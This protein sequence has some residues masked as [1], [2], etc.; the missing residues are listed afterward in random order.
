M[1]GAKGLRDLVPVVM[2]RID[3][4]RSTAF[5][6]LIRLLVGMFEELW[7][8]KTPSGKI[9]PL[10]RP[11]NLPPTKSIY[12]NYCRCHFQLSKPSK[13]VIHITPINS[14][15]NSVSSLYSDPKDA[16]PT[17]IKGAEASKINCFSKNWV[18]DETNW[19]LLLTSVNWI[20]PICVVFVR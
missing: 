20:I 1:L 9:S 2:L 11:E 16:H 5:G 7:K 14:T 3:R 15:A 18:H 10:G 12:P 13:Y 4:I 8:H 17:G 6:S 19:A